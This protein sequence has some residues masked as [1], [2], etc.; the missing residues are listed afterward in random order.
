MRCVCFWLLCLSTL[1]SA[2]AGAPL[3]LSLGDSEGK[4]LYSVPMQSGSV[5][6]IRYR[7]SVALSPVTDYFI[8]KDDGIWLDRTVYQDF[9]AGLPHKPEGGQVMRS[10]EGHITISG[11]NRKLGS[12]QLRVGR[13][14]NH[15]L[16]LMPRQTRTDQDSDLLEIPLATIA[17][18]G[19]AITFAIRRA[20]P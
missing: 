8:V 17:R 11:F 5:F 3:L 16:L 4:V 18:P 1:D 9:G 13:V 15:T 6:A 10:Q 20:G 19:T 14:A 2:N 12:F 7:H